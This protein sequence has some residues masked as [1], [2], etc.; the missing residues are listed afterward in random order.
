[1][2]RY[3]NL[4]LNAHKSPHFWK[5][6]QKIPPRKGVKKMLLCWVKDICN[7]ATLIFSS[8]PAGTFQI[9]FVRKVRDLCLLPISTE[10][11][12]VTWSD[13]FKAR[14]AFFRHTSTPFSRTIFLSLSFLF[15][16]SNV[17]NF[18]MCPF[19]T[20]NSQYRH[21]AISSPFHSKLK[22]IDFSIMSN[23]FI[24]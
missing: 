1:M 5:R 16:K 13:T 18:K 12:F 15:G 11:F 4:L 17:Y 9:L 22:T 19:L 6:S 21:S 10:R 3:C 24:L 8:N 14:T 20:N 7:E 23:L 2:L